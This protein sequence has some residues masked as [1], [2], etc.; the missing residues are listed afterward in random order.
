VL[1]HRVDASRRF[2]RQIRRFMVYAICNP[3]NVDKVDAGALEEI[4]GMLKNGI[5]LDELDSAKRATSKS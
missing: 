2:A 3:A 1:R 4:G 5:S